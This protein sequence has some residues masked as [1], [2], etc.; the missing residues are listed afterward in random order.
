[1]QTESNK[2]LENIEKEYSK[3]IA[4]RDHG[5]SVPLGWSGE[6][7]KDIV[8]ENLFNYCKELQL[9]LRRIESI[10]FND[11]CTIVG[12]F[13]TIP[14]LDEDIEDCLLEPI[15][16]PSHEAVTPTEFHLKRKPANDWLFTLA[17]GYLHGTVTKQE[18]GGYMDHGDLTIEDYQFI[19]DYTKPRT[20]V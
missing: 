14:I 9:R 4:H 12:G 2:Y 18:L 20:E 6:P 5:P 10:L 19:I 16:F 7:D 11:L 3:K 13:D 1:M 17:E 8:I 15:R